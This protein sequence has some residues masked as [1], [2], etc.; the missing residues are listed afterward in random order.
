MSLSSKNKPS[1]TSFEEICITNLKEGYKPT[2]AV[3]KALEE[4]NSSR[5]LDKGIS[6][7]TAWRK[8]KT[9]KGQKIRNWLNI[10]FFAFFQK[11]IVILSWNL[12]KMGM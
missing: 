9:I 10:N 2:R 12:D 6:I 11:M 1:K 3:E 7:S 5:P 8:Y 4:H